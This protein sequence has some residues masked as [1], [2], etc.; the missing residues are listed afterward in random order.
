M[1]IPKI[2]HIEGDRYTESIT[3]MCTGC[4]EFYSYSVRQYKG[5][6]GCNISEFEHFLSWAKWHAAQHECF[7][8]GR[9]GYLPPDFFEGVERGVE[10]LKEGRVTPWEP[11]DDCPTCGAPSVTF[12]N[13]DCPKCNPPIEED[14]D[15]L[16][17]C[18]PL[19]ASS[20]TSLPTLDETCSVCGG[21]GVVANEAAPAW[22]EYHK[23][24]HAAPHLTTE[25]RCNRDGSEMPPEEEPCG[26]CE[27]TGRIP[28][29]AG[30]EIL[31]FLR[32]IKY[33]LQ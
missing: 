21:V 3:L 9:A 16:D 30:R 22:W 1:T 28:T 15:D 6:F 7:L 8:A 33:G 32:R 31:D 10:A 2:E 19:D 12:V 29:G 24:G 25:F 23:H 4:N 14:E 11:E 26:E 17:A 20:E 18:P 27:G 13:G 5:D